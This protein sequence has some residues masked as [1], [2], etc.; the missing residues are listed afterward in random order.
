MASDHIYVTPTASDIASD[1]V[2][3]VDILTQAVTMGDTIEKIMKRISKDGDWTSLSSALNVTSEQAEEIQDLLAAANN[4][5]KDNDIDEL[6][7]RC[8]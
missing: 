4:V 6:I 7:K 8:G 2:R 3:F 5:L 1:F